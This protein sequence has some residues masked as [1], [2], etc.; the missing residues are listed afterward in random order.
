MKESGNEKKIQQK[1]EVDNS[2]RHSAKLFNILG[3]GY[4]LAKQDLKDFSKFV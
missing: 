4:A 1:S 3:L 2:V